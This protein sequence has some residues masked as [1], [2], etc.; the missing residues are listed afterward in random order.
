MP[1]PVRLVP[2]TELAGLGYSLSIFLISVILA[3]P[4]D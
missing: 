1:F 3:D 2:K 4:T